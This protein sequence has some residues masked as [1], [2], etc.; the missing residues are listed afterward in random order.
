MCRMQIYM[1]QEKW[2]LAIEEGTEIADFD[3][4]TVGGP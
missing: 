2:N 4:S 3:L 1:T